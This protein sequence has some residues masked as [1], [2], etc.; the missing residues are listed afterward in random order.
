ADLSAAWLD[1]GEALE[2]QGK[3]A[4]ALEAADKARRM[5]HELTEKVL[6]VLPEADQLDFLKNEDIPSLDRALAL[7]QTPEHDQTTVELAAAWVLN[8]KGRAQAA[9][10]QRVL[11]A[12][13]AR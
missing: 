9:I 6:P 7:L 12:R 5:M 8:Q 4:E 11:S 1:L 3:H 10:A 2:A 13:E